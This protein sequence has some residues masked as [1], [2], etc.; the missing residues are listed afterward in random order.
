MQLELQNQHLFTSNTFNS[1]KISKA[2]IVKKIVEEEF[3]LRPKGSLINMLELKQANIYNQLQPM[4]ILAEY[5]MDDGG[6]SWEKTDLINS[7]KNSI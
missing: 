7:L 3:D 2:A 4:G 5:L 1:E 6:F